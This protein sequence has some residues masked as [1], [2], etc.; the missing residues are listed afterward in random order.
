MRK[1]LAAAGLGTLLVL[2]PAAHVVAQP[3]TQ[4]TVE[5]EDDDD[6]AGLWG[7]AG[8][9]GLLGLAGLAGLK[10]R[11]DDVSRPTSS[12]HSTTLPPSH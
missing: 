11:R 6:D 3:T 12:A 7:L 4:P 9:A 5:V 10:R 8:L 2:G 1:T